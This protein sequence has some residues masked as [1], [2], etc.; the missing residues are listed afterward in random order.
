MDPSRISAIQDFPK[1]RNLRE[2]RG[3][4]RIVNYDRPSC[5]SLSDL[6]LPLLRLLKKGK[7]WYWERN[8]ERVFRVI[9]AAYLEA[10]VPSGAP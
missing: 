8:E 3:F 6:T 9:K 7:P 4:L 1:P 5:K 10:V 2:L